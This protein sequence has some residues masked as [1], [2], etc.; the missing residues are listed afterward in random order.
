MFASPLHN[1]GLLKRKNAIFLRFHQKIGP[2]GVKVIFKMVEVKNKHVD[3]QILKHHL[4]LLLKLSQWTGC[5][6][7][8]PEGLTMCNTIIYPGVVDT[9]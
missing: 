2:I 6:I 7:F 1:Q 5:S 9:I 8:A 3:K 4:P